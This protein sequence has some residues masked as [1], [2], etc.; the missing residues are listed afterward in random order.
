MRLFPIVLGIIACAISCNFPVLAA[1]EKL[2]PAESP[3]DES[4]SAA[5]SDT[6]IGMPTTMC[7][8]A[9]SN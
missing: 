7:V 4:S 2:A 9:N 5:R 8:A 3:S 1:D 6:T